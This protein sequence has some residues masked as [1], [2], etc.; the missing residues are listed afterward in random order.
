MAMPHDDGP[1]GPQH[2]ESA[3]G[4]MPRSSPT[5]SP[6]PRGD[7]EVH[8]RE[9]GEPARPLI[10]ELDSLRR[11]VAQLEE[12][13]A[14]RRRAEAAIRR[15]LDF[16]R[17]VSAIS[18]HFVASDLDTAIDASLAEIG[19][20]SGASRAYLFQFRNHG[21]T[22]DNT[23]EWC[24][25]GVSPEIQN[26]QNL[27]SDQTPWWMSKLRK[28]EAIHITDTSAMP[29]EASS[30]REILQRQGIKSLLALPVVA[31]GELVGFLGFDNVEETGEWP[32]EDLA[33]LRVCSEILGSTLERRRTEEALRQSE[34]RFRAIFENAAI[35]VTVVDA[36]A[37]LVD[38]NP[39]MHR[40]LGYAD[41]EL[42]GLHISQFTHPE[43]LPAQM[44]LHRELFAGKRDWFQLEKR[45]IRKNGL[46]IWGRLT[47]SLVRSAEGEPLFSIGMVEDTTERK[48]AEAERERLLAQL[49]DVNQRLALSSLQAK[50]LAEEAQ[51]R[52]AELEAT[53]AS[54]PDGL[55]VYGPGGEAVRMNDAASRMLG[56]TLDRAPQGVAERCAMLQV[57]TPDGRP[58]PPEELPPYRA[59]RGETVLGVMGC[60]YPATGGARWLSC[61][62]APIRTPD[63]QVIGA[64]AV[65]TD[66]TA[67]RDLQEQQEIYGRMISHDLRSPLTSVMGHAQLL[68]RT[69]A[70]KGLVGE[71]ESARYILE[72]ARRMSAMIRDLAETSHLDA[73]RV[74]LHR[75][76]VDLSQLLAEILPRAGSVGDRAR[77]RAE[78]PDR[79]LWVVCDEDRIERV[80]VNLVTNA[81]KYS[82]AESDVVVAARRMDEEVQVSVRDSGP[83][84]APDHIPAIF[85]RF[86]RVSQQDRA[87]GMGLG[88]YIARM[89]VEA[90]GGRIWVESEVGK[91]ST[92]SFTLP[93]A[94]GPDLSQP[95][96]TS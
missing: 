38:C 53:I 66:V 56:Y 8:M 33:I 91:G 78:L 82:P 86:Y 1:A 79:P 52:L 43:D 16:E 31:G 5:A 24:A 74:E 61:S 10:E 29:P 88:L 77:I 32:E 64:V 6:D 51:R 46:V 2:G 40:M 9:E 60:I 28:G 75:Q 12:A 83:G 17:T 68:T 41:G 34:A 30:E 89:L 95:R 72:N 25:E 92:F 13:E 18:S 55:V 37:R 50:Q 3:S 47:R 36:D 81:L 93:L 59:M 71:A 7:E 26:L 11:R 65:L 15:R 90:H 54:I 58:F 96:F 39:A 69:L 73:G 70:A 20:L 63:G 22:M 19:R 85:D 23:H 35:G 49:Q 45:Y 94:T 42:R 14:Q 4:T 87:P 57:K 48:R 21:A 84:I 80:V 44:E 62:A 76:L 27:R 67:L